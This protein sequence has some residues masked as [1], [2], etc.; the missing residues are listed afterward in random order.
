[1]DVVNLELLRI[2][3]NFAVKFMLQDNVRVYSHCQKLCFI[4]PFKIG[5]MDFYG[6]VCTQR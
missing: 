6:A 2:S 5:P 3:L 4:S 1:M